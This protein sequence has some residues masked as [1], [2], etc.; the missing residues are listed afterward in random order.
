MK[1]IGFKHLFVLIC[2]FLSLGAGCDS[3]NNDLIEFSIIKVKG[4]SVCGDSCY[5][6]NSKGTDTEYII[7]SQED[8]ESL[9]ECNPAVDF[10]PEI[11]F[12]KYI[13]IAGTRRVTGICPELLEQNLFINSDG[14][15][16]IFNLKI[17]SGGYAAIGSANF[18]SLILREDFKGNEIEINSEIIP[19]VQN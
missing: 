16:V 10:K 19:F 6:K 8:F 2:T 5:I 9:F 14:L 4:L 17:K 3:D 18:H 11:D 15:K 7:N 13:L 1:I 12:S